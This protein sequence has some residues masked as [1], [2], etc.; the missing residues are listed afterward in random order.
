MTG[1]TFEEEER[2]SSYVP[3]AVRPTSKVALVTSTL[4]I[5]SRISLFLKYHLKSYQRF[6]GQLLRSLLDGTETSISRLRIG[7]IVAE[8]LFPTFFPSSSISKNH[9]SV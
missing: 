8:L 2:G 6:R 3:T 1:G 5:R 7:T 4:A 9:G